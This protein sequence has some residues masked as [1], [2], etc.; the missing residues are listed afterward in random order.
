MSLSLKYAETPYVLEIRGNGMCKGP[1]G[2]KSLMSGTL[3]AR[4]QEG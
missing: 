4:G 1:L 3:G 2:G